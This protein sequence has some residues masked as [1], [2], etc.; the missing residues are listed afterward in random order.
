MHE[1]KLQWDK[2]RRAAVKKII[3][4]DVKNGRK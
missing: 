2:G 3:R 1:I 4:R